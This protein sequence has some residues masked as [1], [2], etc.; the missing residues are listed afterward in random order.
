MFVPQVWSRGPEQAE[1]VG[2]V[3]GVA[4][5]NPNLTNKHS[6]LI[7]MSMFLTSVLVFSD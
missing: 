6:F 3:S 4:W 5:G 7:I 2:L 1:M